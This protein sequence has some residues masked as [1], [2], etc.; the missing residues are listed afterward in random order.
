[1]T[2]QTAQIHDVRI[3]RVVIA[4]DAAGMR[5][6]LSIILGSAGFDCIE[7]ADGAEAFDIVLGG[8]IDLVVTD[9]DM[10]EMDGFGLIS[11][12]GLLSAHHG[13]PPV[14]V[15]SGL[16]DETLAERRP[17]LRAAAALLAKP[18]QPEEVLKAVARVMNLRLAAG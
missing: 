3:P 9:L 10:P 11:A 14:I 2:A 1:M 12:I 17:E 7:A 8:G 16:L 18:V 5:A 4:D 15:V 13:R 6:Y